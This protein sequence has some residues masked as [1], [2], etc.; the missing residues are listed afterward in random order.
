MQSFG[1]IQINMA[2][3][4]R[5][6][7]LCGFMMLNLGWRSPSDSNAVLYSF[8]C[9]KFLNMTAI[10]LIIIPYNWVEVHSLH[11]KSFDLSLLQNRHYQASTLVYSVSQPAQ[12]K[13][14]FRYGL[15]M[16]LDL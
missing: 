14:Q 9:A 13:P 12:P 6:F 15:N 2:L 11:P 7:F 1:S 16:Y 3:K 4:P 10:I 8:Q 5:A